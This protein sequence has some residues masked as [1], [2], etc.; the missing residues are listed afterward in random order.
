M[1][2][3]VVSIF[4]VMVLISP[5]RTHAIGGIVFDPSNLAQN[6]ITAGATL[7]TFNDTIL[8]RILLNAAN[9]FIGN[10]VNRFT[11]DTIRWINSGFQGGGPAYIV[12]PQ[13]YF[14]NVANR[15]MELQ[16]ASIQG[17]NNIFGNAIIGTAIQSV[18]NGRLPTGK[19]LNY[20]LS[21]TVQNSLCTEA[22]IT[23][24]ATKA[25]ECLILIHPRQ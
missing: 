13:A 3:L 17:T 12:N 8:Y 22:N 10:L 25:I 21:N 7:K 11:E 1:K 2:K 5:S 20:T 16:L 23:Q 18:R 9:I 14:K 24:M 19:Q 15:E 6:I 4:I